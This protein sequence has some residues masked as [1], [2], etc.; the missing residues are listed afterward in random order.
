MFLAA[1][2]CFAGRFQKAC[3]VVRVTDQLPTP[4]KRRQR[5]RLRQEG[6]QSLRE[7]KRDRITFVTDI[8]TDRS[9]RTSATGV[10]HDAHDERYELDPAL[11][12]ASV[13]KAASVKAKVAACPDGRPRRR[14]TY[15]IKLKAEDQANTACMGI[16]ACHAQ[17]G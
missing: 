1:A 7:A 10:M 12:L 14:K 17:P 4:K 16:L 9:K 13:N 2:T 15:V 3:G 8:E 5:E 6:P 11:N